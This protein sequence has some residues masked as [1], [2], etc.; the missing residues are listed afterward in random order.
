MVTTLKFP[1]PQLSYLKEID[2]DLNMTGRHYAVLATSSGQIPEEIALGIVKDLTKA[3]AN[4]LTLPELRYVFTMIKI[5]SLEDKYT[6]TLACT[7]TVNGQ[8]CGH[9][10]TVDARL[11]ESDLNRTDKKYKVPRIKFNIS[12]EE[13]EW[14]VF[15]P[16]C[17]DE[18]ELI[19]WFT[20]D[21][22]NTLESLGNDKKVSMDYTYLRGL[23]HLRDPETME[24][25]L[26]DVS[27][28]DSMLNTLDIND[29]KSVSK[30]YDLMNEVDSYGVQNKIYHVNCKECGG[31]LV[32]RLPI[33]HGLVD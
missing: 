27:E 29:F 1:A 15:P 14:L 17:S 21:K 18:I 32:F 13:K 12:G 23:L 2:V 24:P 8:K 5:N 11:S 25:A 16:K 19:K 7:H 28:Y 22:G 4:S 6:V 30:L 3:D 20:N 10:M 9:K 33:L 31:P 26:H